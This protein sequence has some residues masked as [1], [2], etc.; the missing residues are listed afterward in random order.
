MRNYIDVVVIVMA[1]KAA[2]DEMTRLVKRPEEEVVQQ[3]AEGA[4]LHVL[5]W[6]NGLILSAKQ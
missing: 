6:V 4:I 3:T 2:D 1:E 5:D